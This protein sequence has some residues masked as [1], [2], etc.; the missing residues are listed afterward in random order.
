[1][2][3]K[4]SVEK[5]NHRK[6]LVKKFAGRRARLLAIANDE[7]QSMDERFLARLKL[8]ELPRNS[9]GI[10][11]RN[12]CEVT[13]R[14]RAFYRKLKMSRVALRELG[15]KGLVPGLVKSSW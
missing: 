3:K 15:N 13:G 8:A 11:V 5:N 6:A 2:A 14:P 9:A 7:S 1:M 4:S 12:R 10:R